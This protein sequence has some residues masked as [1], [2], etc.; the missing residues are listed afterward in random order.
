M[1]VQFIAICA[2]VALIQIGC[3]GASWTTDNRAAESGA[4]DT[5]IDKNQFQAVQIHEFAAIPAGTGTIMA[6]IDTGE[7]VS[8]SDFVAAVKKQNQ[9]DGSP[10]EDGFGQR[11]APLSTGMSVASLFYI[12]F[13]G[14]GKDTDVHPL[15]P[16]V[17]QN[18]THVHITVK[19]E[20][21]TPDIAAWS[22]IHV[23]K[24]VDDQQRK[25]IVVFD[26]LHKSIC[27]RTCA[28]D[29]P[30]FSQIRDA[31][32]EG[33]RSTLNSVHIDVASTYVA[34]AAYAIAILATAALAVAT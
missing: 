20:A 29:P 22:K 28:P 34:A 9:N 8:E 3:E 5:S 24:F 1:Q 19:K 18:V 13:R 21:S 11:R 31:I 15:N 30:S 16:C 14:F 2:A 10:V 32:A 23:G 4:A 25:C 6:K 33:L 27:I 26:N 7:Q 17:S 12:H